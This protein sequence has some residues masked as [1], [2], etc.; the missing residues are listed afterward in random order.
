M[1][2]ILIG[3]KFPTKEWRACDDIAQV[4]DF[5]LTLSVAW[6][7]ILLTTLT[8]TQ[9]ADYGQLQAV[10]PLLPGT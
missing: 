8:S 5:F 3:V 2:Q 6:Y 4:C 10:V 7:T 1:N 9:E